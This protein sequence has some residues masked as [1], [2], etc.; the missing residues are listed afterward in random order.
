MVNDRRR[1][2]PAGSICCRQTSVKQSTFRSTPTRTKRTQHQVCTISRFLRPDRVPD[3]VVVSVSTSRPRDV[4]TFRVGLVS[5]K[6]VNVSVSS[7]SRSFTSRA[8]DQFSAKL[9]RPQYA[10][11]TGFSHCKPML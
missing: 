8:Q 1:C 11:W 7:R 3:R 2:W 4:P 6:I 9:C 5:R 10:V